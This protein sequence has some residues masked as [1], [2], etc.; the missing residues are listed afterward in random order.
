MDFGP[1]GHVNDS[2][3]MLSHTLHYTPEQYPPTPTS[4]PFRN[5]RVHQ[6]SRDRLTGKKVQKGRLH[7]LSRDRLT[8]KKAQKGRREDG[9]L[10]ICDEKVPSRK[11]EALDVS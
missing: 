1:K 2:P 9:T 10:I 11:L 8:G 6:L 5:C 3:W 7:Q 4:R